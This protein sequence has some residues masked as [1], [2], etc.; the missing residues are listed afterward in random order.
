MSTPSAIGDRL[1][2]VGRLNVLLG[3]GA[4]L[5]ASAGKV[6][7]GAGTEPATYGL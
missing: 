7:A 3:E 4:G 5:F 2:I 1:E 6:V